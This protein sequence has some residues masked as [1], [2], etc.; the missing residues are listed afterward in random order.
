MSPAVLDRVLSKL[1][2]QDDP[3]LLVGFGN[4]DDAGVYLLQD[5][6]A[7]VQTTDFF[8]PIIDDPYQYGQIA[9]A[10]SLSDVYA[11]GGRPLTA[12]SIVCYPEEGDL[13]AL[14]RILAGGMQKMMEARCTIVGGHMVRDAEA[15]F[16]YAI[17]GTID[18]NNIWTNAGARPGDILVLT[19]PLGTGVIATAIR[20]GEAESS[21]IEAAV[22]T[23]GR[24]NKDA[25]EAI[26][27]L[28]SA[29]HSVTDITGFGFLGHAMEMAAA[30]CVS[31]R[32]ETGRIELLDGALECAR[33]G[34]IAG[35]LKKN[36]QYVGDCARFTA[37]VSLEMQHLLFDPQ[38]SGGLLIALQP[39]SVEEACARLIK[40]DCPAMQVGKVIEKTSPLIEICPD[41]ACS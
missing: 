15:K 36:R 40:A 32:L 29:I 6:L 9:A 20:A 16:G 21:W 8:T 24:L 26:A 1:P 3:R 19:K 34:F 25:A 5:G 14:E 35:G 38:T 41:S 10:N 37:G 28:G 23:M 7:L 22:R 33:R 39:D 11:M 17:T 4:K 2:R 13:D 27:P 18:P 31:L 12:L 30:S